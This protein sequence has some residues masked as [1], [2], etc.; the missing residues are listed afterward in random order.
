MPN[1]FDLPTPAGQEH[2]FTASLCDQF[3]KSGLDAHIDAMGNLIA[4]LPCENRDAK[5]LLFSVNCDRIGCIVHEILPS[6]MLCVSAIGNFACNRFAFSQVQFTNG[7][8]GIF[9]PKS[10]EI[11]EKDEIC[12]YQIDIGATGAADAQKRISIGDCCVFDAAKAPLM[13]HRAR[14][15]PQME[16]CKLLAEFAQSKPK[17]PYRLAFAFT[18]Q[19]ALN[20]RGTKTAAFAVAPDYAI[21]LT[22]TPAKNAIQLGKGVVIRHRDKSA[23]C[24]VAWTNHIRACAKEQKVLFQEEVQS[25]EA[26][27]LA[28]LQ[29]SCSAKC[30]A[31]ALPIRN[32]HTNTEILDKKDLQSLQSLVS[33][34]VI[35]SF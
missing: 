4:Y 1:L 9:F 21:E 11:S 17:S 34:L 29:T 7:V 33:A 13:H 23:V 6:G 27:S 2:A 19:G 12:D 16:L 25:K 22:L 3:Q 15:L 31:L 14:T 32:L 18:V 5:T 26:S 8:R 28:V 30:G 10:G 20:A 35:Q 24:D